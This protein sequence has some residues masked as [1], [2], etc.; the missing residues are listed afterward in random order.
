MTPPTPL[1]RDRV[2]R[3]AI[4]LADEHGIGALTMRRLG[5]SLGVEAMS[6]Y[7]HVAGKDDILDGIVDRVFAEIDLP[8][9][10]P[11]W[12][13]AM[14][15]R[16]TSARDAFA[17]HPWAVPI[18]DSRLSPG[19]AT[20]R[21][22]DWVIGRLRAGGF[23]IPMAA[24]AFAVLDAFVFGFAVQEASLP[25]D[26]S[27][28]ATDVAGSAL[29]DVTPDRYP[30]LVALATEHV[31]KPGYAF[32]DEFAFGLELILDGLERARDSA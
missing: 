23:A 18:M 9:D 11:D 4:A 30:H 29:R 7:K 25:F 10:A 5:Q 16:A 28:E 8:D 1:S 6:L 20:L 3:A 2:L 21:H 32:S 31:M 17:R 19:P 13:T 24:H 12:K 15:A 14:R 22:H 27:N 26:T